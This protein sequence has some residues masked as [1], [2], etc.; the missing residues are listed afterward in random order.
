MSSDFCVE[1][2]NEFNLDGLSVQL[3]IDLGA[4]SPDEPS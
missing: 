3:S 2:E 4:D 1:N